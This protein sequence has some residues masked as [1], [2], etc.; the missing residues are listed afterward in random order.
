MATWQFN[1]H[2]VPRSALPGGSAPAAAE[3]THET[4]EDAGWW[5]GALLPAD[6]VSRLSDLLPPLESW[7][8]SGLRWG[9]ED[10][11]RI[12]IWSQEGVMESVWI[13][14]DASD[15]APAPVLAG[16]AAFAAA[17][18]GV[19]ISEHLDVI[20]PEAAKLEAALRGSRAARFVADPER[21][22]RR[23][24]VGGLDDV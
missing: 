7:H 15:V 1:L 23:L 12:E 17:C 20:G 4:L 11:H 14:L 10:G 13:R 18:D 16:L 3:L 19:F 5:A 9:A 22:L 21:Y 6:Y 2:L 8:P 24:S